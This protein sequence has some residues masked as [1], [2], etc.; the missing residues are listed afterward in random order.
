[1]FFPS[2][3]SQVVVGRNVHVSMRC[4]FC[5]IRQDAHELMLPFTFNKTCEHLRA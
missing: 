3:R 2:L 1:M 4:C 5:A